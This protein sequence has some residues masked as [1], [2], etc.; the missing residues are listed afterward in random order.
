MLFTSLYKFCI[1]TGWNLEA[2]FLTHAILI[3]FT[4]E[5]FML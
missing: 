3:W 4:I 1:N 5:G 2:S